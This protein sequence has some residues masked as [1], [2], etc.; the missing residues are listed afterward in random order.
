MLGGVRVRHIDELPRS[1]RPERVSIGV[2]ATPAGAAQDAADRLVTR[3]RHQHLELRPGRARGAA[4]D[5]GAQGR[6][7]RRAADPQLPRA[8]PRGRRGATAAGGTGRFPTGRERV[9]WIRHVDRRH[10]SQPPHGPAVVARAAGGR[11]RATCPRR[12]PASPPATTSA[13]PS[14]SARATAPRSTPS[15]SGSTA[16][17]PT[18]A[19]SSASSATSPPTS[20]TRTSTASTTTPR[21]R[22]CSRSPPGST[23]RCSAR[24]RSSVRCARRGSSP[25]T[26]VAPR[27]RS[28]LLFRHALETRQAGPHRDGDRPRHRV[29]QP[30]RRR[31]GHRAAR[32][33]RRRATCS[34]SA[35]ARWARASPSRCH[36]G[37][38]DI[39]VAN[40]TPERG[41][42]LA[43]R[44]GGRAIG[45]DRRRP[46]RSADA[47][48]VADVHRRRRERGRLDA[49]S[50][51]HKR[52]DRAAADRRHRRA[53]RRR[54][55]GRRARRRDAARPRRPARLGRPR[56]RRCAPARPTRVR[57][58]VAEEV[59]RF[60]DRGHG[61][62]GGAARGPA[63]RA[64]RGDAPSELER[65]A[66]RLAD[67]RRRPSAT[68]SR[69]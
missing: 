36:A 27:P 45:L 18:S 1:C 62:P 66:G 6:P 29:G 37:A 21:S 10:R 25:R 46:T 55:R 68:R 40:R 9:G 19:T 31:D 20:C 26:R 64:R 42:H 63:A 16:P 28:N 69:R 54:P 13:R 12:S 57:D 50:R 43:E 14:C 61:P 38:A 49:A 15:P 48:V 4:G 24:A 60:G 67:A 11:A 47:D 17:T 52:V 56:H 44:V 32:R 35:P 59:E 33:A 5:R 41:S 39:I 65:F 7:R 58:I 34:S 8:A 51:P 22:T 3:R 23:R 53:P 2:V 30:R